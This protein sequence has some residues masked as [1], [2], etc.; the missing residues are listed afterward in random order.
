FLG[1]V[2]G[3]LGGGFHAARDFLGGGPLFGD[4]RRNRAADI[5]DLADDALD[6]GDRLDRTVG[7]ALHAGDLRA[8]LLGGAAGLA[9]QR[10]HLA[11]TTAKPRPA[12][13]ARAASM[14]ALS[15]RRLVC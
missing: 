12:S 2:G 11:A 1:G 14:V 5:A 13:P 8:D 4:G 9:G 10:L 6:R 15:A 3:A 7:G